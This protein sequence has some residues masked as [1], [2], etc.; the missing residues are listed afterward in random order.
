MKGRGHHRRAFVVCVLVL[1]TAGSGCAYL[2]DRGNDL[3][4]V[5]E[6][7]ITVTPRLCP[8][9]AVRMNGFGV[10]S[11]GYSRSDL[12]YLGWC[13]RQF[14]LLH[15]EDSFWGLLFWGRERLWI[16]RYG[17]ESSEAYPTEIYYLKKPFQ[18]REPY[19]VGLVGA[20]AG[21][22][23][24]PGRAF[25]ECPKMLHLGWIGIFANCSPMDLVDFILGWSTLDIGHDDGRS[26]RGA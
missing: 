24:P 23:S 15:L 7:G 26:R 16:G 4:D 11:W 21:S 1:L 22:P 13:D 18:E 19:A 6:L 8:T 17:Q 3:S 25:G 9:L 2:R 12:A 14:G 10:V 5:I 20:F